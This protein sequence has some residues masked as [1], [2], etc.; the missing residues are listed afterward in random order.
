MYA[1]YPRWNL[2][3]KVSQTST[4]HLSRDPLLGKRLIYS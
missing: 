3:K 1:E 2:D 4:A